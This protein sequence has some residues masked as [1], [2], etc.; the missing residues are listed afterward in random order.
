MRFPYAYPHSGAACNASLPDLLAAARQVPQCACVQMLQDGLHHTGMQLCKQICFHGEI[1]NQNLHRGCSS[2]RIHSS[3]VSG[4]HAPK[5]AVLLSK[6][7]ISPKTVACMSGPSRVARRGRKM[8]QAA[9]ILVGAVA[10]LLGATLA[11]RLLRR[12]RDS[13]R[14]QPPTDSG[15]RTP[16]AVE[17]RA[18]FG[19]PCDVR[20]DSKAASTAPGTPTIKVSCDVLTHVDV[21]EWLQSSGGAPAATSVACLLK[22]CGHF[23]NARRSQA[24]AI[25]ACS[26]RKSS[27]RSSSCPPTMTRTVT[28]PWG[29]R[30]KHWTTLQMQLH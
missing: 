9:G 6:P 8:S 19:S 16:T 12:R 18:A 14:A 7:I 27:S 13:K 24:A 5:L 26:H 2:R 30:T 1:I 4:C 15:T 21:I 29:T 3:M 25:P 22:R 23:S 20:S 11:P 10:T 17:F 28:Q